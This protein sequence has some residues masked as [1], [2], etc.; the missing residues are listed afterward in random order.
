MPPMKKDMDIIAKPLA[1]ASCS[2]Y[3]HY[4]DLLFRS[5]TKP[6]AD[7]I[8]AA[9]RKYCPFAVK[10]LLEPGCGSGRLV[11]EMAKRGYTMTGFDVNKPSLTYLRAELRR[12]H[13]RAG[14]FH[15][16]MACFRI[17]HQIDAAFCTFN[18]FRHL[19]TEEAA[20]SHLECVAQCLKPGGIYILGFHLLPLDVDPY[21][22]ERWTAK[23]RGT[24][25]TATLRVLSSNRRS[26]HEQIRLSLFIRTVK[27]VLRIRSEFPLRMY[28][29]K[30]FR[31]LLASVPELE[32]CDVFDFW[33]QIDRPLSLD[34]WITD[35]VFVLRKR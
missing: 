26:R 15:A 25:V 33:Y 32:L 30:Q 23:E 22:C 24:E 6:E 3:P 13:L 5:E 2:D 8:E 28:T 9:C 1:N 34:D 20:R 19:L 10:R 4:F 11:V 12:S 16:D 18:T 14:V 35:T 21:S 29:A 17:R 27:R 31:C 7:F